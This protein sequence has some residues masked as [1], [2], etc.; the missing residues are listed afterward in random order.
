[1][2]PLIFPRTRRLA[3]AVMA[4]ALLAAP[5][6]AA[7]IAPGQVSDFS[8]D[9]ESWSQGREATELA[10]LTRN[11]A[12]GPSGAADPFMQIVADARGS[13]R[14][15]VAFN[16][17]PDWTGDYIGAGLTALTMSVDNLG[18]T[19]LRLHLAFGTSAT[20]DSSGSWIASSTPLILPAASGWTDVRFSLSERDFVVVQDQAGATFDSV[21]RHVVAVRI[22]HASAPG[23]RGTPITATLGVDA[24][25]A[26]PEPATLS[27][28]IAAGAF[29]LSRR[30]KI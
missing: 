3:P 18:A 14:G 27:I 10:G 8:A 29:L 24:I 21:M 16:L 17:S 9:L 23:P 11:S 20:P 13:H 1:M 2:I 22:V 5:Q 19:E 26:V 28:S 30:R 15:I 25:R 4:C 7:A 12:G 6:P